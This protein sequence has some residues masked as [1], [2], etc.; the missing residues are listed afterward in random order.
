MLPHVIISPAALVGVRIVVV[1]MLAAL[2][3]IILSVRNAVATP[4]ST[5]VCA[6]LGMM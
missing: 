4:S 3:K 5:T 2:A 1:A 6:M